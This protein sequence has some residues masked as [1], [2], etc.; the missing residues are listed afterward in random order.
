MLTMSRHAGSVALGLALAVLTG[1]SPSAGRH[2]RSSSPSPSPPVSASV[3][4]TSAPMLPADVVYVFNGSGVPCVASHAIA[5]LIQHGFDAKPADGGIIETALTTIA[6]PS[7]QTA[8]AARVSRGV[9]GVRMEP[10]S[11][12]SRVTL[13]IGQN[14]GSVFGADVGHAYFDCPEG[15]PAPVASPSY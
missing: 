10:T 11:E 15:Q 6:Y 2:E 5:A 8:L 13:T 9:P 12:V 4:T 1:C 7:T 3:P 14:G